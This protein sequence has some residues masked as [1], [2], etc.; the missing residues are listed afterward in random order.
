MRIF[1]SGKLEI[2]FFID[3]LLNYL[4]GKKFSRILRKEGQ[5]VRVKTLNNGKICVNKKAY[6]KN[7]WAIFLDNQWNNKIY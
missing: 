6:Y 4:K 7:E 2:N 1:F 3:N 5:N